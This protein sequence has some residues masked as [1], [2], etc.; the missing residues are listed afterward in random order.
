[1]VIHENRGLNAHIEDVARRVA[2][3]GFIALAPDALSP[4]GNTPDDMDKA[5]EM[6]GKL[7]RKAL[8][9]ALGP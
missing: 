7:D 2:L 8:R 4:L 5:R 6:I 9:V 3:A 1:M